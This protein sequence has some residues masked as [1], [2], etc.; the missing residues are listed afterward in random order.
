MD[1]ATTPPASNK[2]RKTKEFPSELANV[3]DEDRSRFV[4]A[5]E[6]DPNP[7]SKTFGSE[8]LV[9]RT[10]TVNIDNGEEVVVDLKSLIVDHLRQLCRNVG[11]VNVG[12]VNKFDCR[13]GLATFIKYQDELERKG[14]TTTSTASRL[15]STICRA[16]NVVFSEQFVNDFFS[17]NDI[18]SRRDHETKK[19]HKSFWINAALAHNSCFESDCS[20]VNVVHIR[21]AGAATAATEDNDTTT[22][23]TNKSNNNTNNSF[24]SSDS[25]NE[26]TNDDAEGN[27]RDCFS[28]ILNDDDDI[29]VE[30]LLETDRFV[31]LMEVNQFETKAF[32]KKILDLFKIRRVM[33]EN[34]TV[35][36]THDNEPWNFVESAM[37]SSGQG[38]GFTKIAVYYFYKR[39]EACDG[40]DAVF[41]QFLDP[42]FVGDTTSLGDYSDSG[43]EEVGDDGGGSISTNSTHFSTRKKARVKVEND[44]FNEKYSTLVDQGQMGLMHME[45]SANREKARFDLEQESAHREKAR[46]N[47]EQESAHRE[48]ARFDLDLNKDKFFARLEVAKA[49]NDLEELAKLKKEA[50]EMPSGR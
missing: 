44:A 45:E 7:R 50:S 24:S 10:V 13:K 41:Q 28:S 43:R 22:T 25:D 1:V 21:N 14:I 37:A 46:F 35:S 29:H 47:L 38:G 23:P 19:T 26:R 17:V 4:M 34:M 6:L 5:L 9:A 39:C 18:H 16:V 20:D 12:S 31:N 3:T 42:A 15:T 30:S 11:V 48:K 40:I 8:C 27:A 32:R 2:K 33:Q 49:M 36:G